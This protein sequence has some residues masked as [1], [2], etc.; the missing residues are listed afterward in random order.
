MKI[1]VRDGR[2]EPDKVDLVFQYNDHQGNV[3][4]LTPGEICDLEDA[5]VEYRLYGDISKEDAK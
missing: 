4:T 5:L 3:V 1:Y 2:F